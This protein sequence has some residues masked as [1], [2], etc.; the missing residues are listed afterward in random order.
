MFERTFVALELAVLWF[1]IQAGGTSV[2]LQGSGFGTSP[3]VSLAGVPCATER[4]HVGSYRGMNLCEWGDKQRAQ[5]F[6]GAVD[7]GAMQTSDTEITCITNPLPP[8][9]ERGDPGAVGVVTEYGQSGAAAG[10]RYDYK[11]L[12]RYFSY[13]W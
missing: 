13:I 11:N 9:E 8:G 4:A 7:C 6:G 10:V 1:T 5:G 3:K 2:T 12:W